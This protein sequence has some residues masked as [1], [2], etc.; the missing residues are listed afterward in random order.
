M[1]AHL[2]ARDW[3]ESKRRDVARLE[4]VQ[5]LIMNECE[6][7]RPETSKPTGI[8]DPTARQAIYRAGELAERMEALRE[9][10]RDLIDSIGQ[11][12]VVIESVRDGLGERYADI[13]EA[14]YIDRLSM[15]A[16]SDRLGVSKSSVH[17]WRNI[18]LDWLDSVGI[19]RAVRKEWDE[20]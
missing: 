4:E 20:L 12:L 7:W 8:S 11:A 1:V 9:E 18:A 6:E 14:V 17:Q 5:S 10:E 19:G 16:A 2:L 15:R 13:L 3:L